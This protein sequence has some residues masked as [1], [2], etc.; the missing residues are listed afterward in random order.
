MQGF[1]R[2]SFYDQQE[3]WELSRELFV[4]AAVIPGQENKPIKSFYC[5]SEFYEGYLLMLFEKHLQMFH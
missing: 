2:C 3:I 1:R 5:L 4:F